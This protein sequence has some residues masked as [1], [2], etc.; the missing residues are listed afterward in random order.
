MKHTYKITGMTCPNCVAHVKS[1]L[2]MV[3]NVSDVEVSLE[4][5]TATIA[6]DKHVGLS[7]F[8]KALGEKYAIATVGHN[9]TTEQAKSWLSTF[10][11][12]LLIFSYILV[13][14]LLIASGK[15]GFDWMKAMNIFMAGF[16]L[17]FSFFKM[18]D[19]DSFAESYSN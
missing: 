11:P 17:A 19:L 18:L 16:F 8:Q 7:T 12:V 5:Q 6:M 4:K 13:I 1:S 9:E 10:K 14:A 2:L 15:E 3:P